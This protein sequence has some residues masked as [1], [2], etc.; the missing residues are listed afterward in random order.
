MSFSE[1]LADRIRQAFGRK[2]GLVE[3]KM[4]GGVGFLLSGNMC[5]GVWQT[6]L[7]VRLDPDDAESLMKQSHVRVFDITGRPMKGWL[8][9]EADG[10]ETDEQLSA[11]L[12]RATRFVETLPAK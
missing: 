10:L 5:V 1:S 4:F 8:L 12:A 7:I 6:A 11:W 3:K 2:R 9:V